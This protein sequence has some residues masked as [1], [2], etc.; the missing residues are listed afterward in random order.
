MAL[1]LAA[2]CVLGMAAS[3]SAGAQTT[4]DQDVATAID[5]GLAWLDAQGAY[6]NP[7]GVGPEVVGLT[8]LALEEKRQNNDPSLPPQ[9]YANASVGD[10]GRMR[11][12][13]R[14]IIDEINAQGGIDFAYRDG[15]YLMA[16]GV[17]MRT[18]GPDKDDGPTTEL[19]G[20]PLT[21]KQAYDQVFD[22]LID[23]QI[24]GQAASPA[25]YPETNGYWCYGDYYG[26]TTCRDSST[27]QLVMA[28]MAAARGVYSD[29]AWSDPTRLATLNAAAA[30]ARNAYTVN[31]TSEDDP[32]KFT[33][34]AC[35]AV[36]PG[37]LGHAYN[38]GGDYNSIQQ[39]AAGAW[40]QLA[41]GADLNDQGV[42]AYL[43]WLRNRYR[44]TDSYVFD[45]QGRPLDG[46]WGASHWYYL[47]S[48][49]KAFTFIQESGVTPAPG[50][51]GLG[52]IGALGPADAPACEVREKRRDPTLDPRVP[53]FGNQG[54]GYYGAETPR[55]YYDFAYEVL[56][57]QCP[58]DATD[59][60]FN[61][62]QFNC[63]SPNP[64]G[65]W[66]QYADQAYGILILLRSVGGGCIDTD[67]D[68]VCDDVDNC[69]ATPNADQADADGDGIG[70]VCDNCVANAN[71]NQED[72]DG[73]GVGDACDN[74]VSTP[75]ANQADADQD[76]VGDV[77]DNCVDTPNPDQ[78]DTDADGIGDAC[79]EGCPDADGDGVCDA[80][81]NC[82]L[83][84]N[85]NQEDA[86]QDGVGDVCD[87]CVGTPNPN[88]A[89]GDGDGVGDACDNCVG[90]PNANQ[91]DAD[92]D[93]VGDVCDNCVDT[94]NAD[95]ADRDGDGVGDACD[96]CVANANPGQQDVDGDGVGDDCD[97]C[98]ETPN[99]GQ[100]D[101]DADGTGDACEVVE[102]VC[103]MDRDGD[104]D[105]NDVKAVMALRGKT[106]PPADPIADADNNGVIT[107]ND[108]RACVLRCTRPSCASQ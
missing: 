70:D 19:D 82:P 69:V 83:N 40:I 90:T 27:T 58:I 1:G 78:A 76:G 88:Q 4:F 35:G 80:D 64:F 51:L 86:D 92:Q 60:A 22:R 25:P 89:D 29:A 52:D 81:D 103:D 65:S 87:N 50:N 9:G 36:E 24:K 104:V 66:N 18:G 37:E 14:Y 77:C 73:D 106:V 79:E 57:H 84:A 7:S 99:P 85:P 68:G 93:G 67:G 108:G 71:P 53:A 75:N 3:A 39:T 74:C 62:G 107:I 105:V 48:A 94:P 28:G 16:L 95:Q 44:Y 56:S 41:G 10:Q 32:L 55:I 91:A 49:N 101:S 38:A 100:E 21:L 102:L 33:F 15:A 98:V 13:V 72:R 5:R 2:T 54:A 97:N 45:G 42:Q 34:A 43:R 6:D 11:R 8:L 59:G 96:N 46:Y 31:G 30:A 20:A 26:F 61:D 63:P 23:S 47:W 12:T 17:Y